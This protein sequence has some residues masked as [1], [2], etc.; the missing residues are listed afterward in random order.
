MKCPGLVRQGLTAK[1]RRCKRRDLEAL[2]AWQNCSMK[3]STGN[4][5]EFMVN[6]ALRKEL[7]GFF[8]KKEIER[9]C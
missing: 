9:Q 4:T 1:G 6:K 2:G 5:S 3:R 7:E 8:G